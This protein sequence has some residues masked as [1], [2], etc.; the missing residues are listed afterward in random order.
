MPITP[1][2][3]NKNTVKD[4]LKAKDRE[5]Q[6]LKELLSEAESE[7]KE[8][9]DFHGFNKPRAGI[10]ESEFLNKLIKRT[11]FALICIVIIL[12]GLY[13]WLFKDTFF[14]D[15]E[16]L[17]SEEGTELEDTLAEDESADQIKKQPEEEKTV[18]EEVKEEVKPANEN[19]FSSGKV[20]EVDSDLGWLN[21][22]T[23]PNVENGK[24]IKKINSGDEYEWLEKTE[25]NW[26]K[27]VIDSK[28]NTGYVSGE[29]LIVK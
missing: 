4:Q 16:K 9:N 12:A 13:P 26:Y 7:I 14:T 25:N 11:A 23:E 24:I 20:V 21:V 18:A 29:Y 3:N 27:L 28:G 10:L 15:D 6:G 22:R 19:I 17:V 5:I 8:L 1:N 2:I